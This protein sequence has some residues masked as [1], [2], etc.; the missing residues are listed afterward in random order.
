LLIFAYFGN[1][2]A[3]LELGSIRLIGPV[4]KIVGSFATCANDQ[5]PSG[6][7]DKIVE[8]AGGSACLHHCEFP[9][10]GEIKHHVLKLAAMAT[11]TSRC[12]A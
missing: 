4:L 10:H 5:Y 8:S 12:L 3:D 11:A 1:C 6:L 9:T 7:N 2:V